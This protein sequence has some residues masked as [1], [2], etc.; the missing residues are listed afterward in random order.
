MY[1]IGQ[2]IAV[3]VQR[4]LPKASMFSESSNARKAFAIVKACTS[5]VEQLPN[6]Q[7]SVPLQSL[8]LFCVGPLQQW[9]SVSCR[10]SPKDVR[11]SP[12]LQGSRLRYE[13]FETNVEP[14]F[15]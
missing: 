13:I 8:K 1:L 10:Q 3:V 15:P 9:P 2:T 6:G 12:P 5:N 14:Y 11:D 4:R 7:R